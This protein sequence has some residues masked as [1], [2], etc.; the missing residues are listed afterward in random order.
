MLTIRKNGL[1]EKEKQVLRLTYLDFCE[2]IIIINR[3]A[4]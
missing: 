3:N 2:E 1:S 4:V